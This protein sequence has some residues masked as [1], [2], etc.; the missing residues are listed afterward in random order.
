MTSLP[1]SSAT[2]TSQRD[3]GHRWGQQKGLPR[4]AGQFS[5]CSF[6]VLTERATGREPA[7]SSLGSMQGVHMVSSCSLTH[8]GITNLCAQHDQ[9]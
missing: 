7:T 4:P 5:N 2:E 8:W 6:H 9:D 1:L 3:A